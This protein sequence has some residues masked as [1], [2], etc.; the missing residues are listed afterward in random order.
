MYTNLSDDN[1]KI[2]AS[3]SDWQLPIFK[4]SEYNISMRYRG[5]DNCQVYLASK[6][7][8]TLKQ[9]ANSIGFY[10]LIELLDADHRRN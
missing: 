2:V 7:N 6:F 3:F 5:D 10:Y 1:K 9:K 8:L 4:Y